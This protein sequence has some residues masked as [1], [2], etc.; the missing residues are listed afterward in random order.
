M[1]GSQMH[2]DSQTKAIVLSDNHPDKMALIG[3]DLD[4][5]WKPSD[6]PGVPREETEHSL[7]L[8]EKA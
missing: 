2:L 1:L 7:D 4:S 3:A 5:A 6:M 8:N